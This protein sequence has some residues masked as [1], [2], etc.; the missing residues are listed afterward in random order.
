M[1][2]KKCA[3]SFVTSKAFERVWHM[4]VL[5]KLRRIDISGSLLSWFANYLKGRR[6]LVVLPGAS[7]NWYS[8]NAGVP[9]CSIVGPFFLSY[10]H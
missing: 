4:S 8:I 3:L 7:S 5:Y 10:L 2:V 1:K 6:Q 9:Q